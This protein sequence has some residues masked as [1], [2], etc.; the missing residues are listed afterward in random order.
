MVAKTDCV[1]DCQ[2]NLHPTQLM[3]L[4]VDE[5]SVKMPAN[6]QVILM[7]IELVVSDT[8]SVVL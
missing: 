2:D 8:K 1:T 7:R 3:L 6:L 4:Q 5:L